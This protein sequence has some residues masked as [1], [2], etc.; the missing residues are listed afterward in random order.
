MAQ[1]IDGN[2]G[3][4]RACE[5]SCRVINFKNKLNVC[6]QR[7]HNHIEKKHCTFGIRVSQSLMVWFQD[8]AATMWLFGCQQ[9]FVTVS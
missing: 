9:T 1:D 4:C 6:V 7:V 3:T 5:G 8:A 2:V